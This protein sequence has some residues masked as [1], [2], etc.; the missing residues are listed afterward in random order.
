MNE[1]MTRRQIAQLF[2][3]SMP[4]VMRWEKSGRLQPVKLGQGSIRHRRSDVGA[5]VNGL[6]KR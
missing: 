4:T 5:F 1:F 2:Q 6:V 3:I